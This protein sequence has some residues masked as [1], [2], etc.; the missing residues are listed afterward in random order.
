MT[1]ISGYGKYVGHR[2]GVTEV[3]QLIVQLQCVQRCRVYETFPRVMQ[4]TLECD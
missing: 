3:H 2:G 1:K 4:R